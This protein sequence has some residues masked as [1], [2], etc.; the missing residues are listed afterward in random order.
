MAKNIQILGPDGEPVRRQILTKELTAPELAGIRSLWHEA[1]APGLTPQRLASVLHACEQGSHH[2]YLTLAEDMEEREPHYKS[3]LD[4]RKRALASV[5][6]VVEAAGED[7]ASRKLADAVED[8]VAQPVFADM[9]GHLADALAKGYAVS[10][11][12]WETSARQ[13]MPFDYRDRD[14]RFR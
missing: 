10:E 11:I 4:T 3:V 13:W 12:M 14:P 7:A 1:I 5:A 9:I 6:P 2:D 8:L